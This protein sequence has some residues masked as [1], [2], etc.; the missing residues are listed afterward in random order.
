MIVGYGFQKKGDVTTSVS[1]I[2]ALDIKDYSAAG[3]DRA[4]VGKMAGVQVLQ[5]TGEPG[6]VSTIKIRGTKSITAGT[7]PL[8]VIDGVAMDR[9]SQAVEMLN[10]NDIESI[11]VLKDA[12]A[13]AIYGSRGANGVIIITTKQG[14]EGERQATAILNNGRHICRHPVEDVVYGPSIEINR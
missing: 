8:Y 12:S 9:G 7:Q 5:T 2:N 10:P 11:E 4:L 14:A 1:S 3:F 13:S 6:T